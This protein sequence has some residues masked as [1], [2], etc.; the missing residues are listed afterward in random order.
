MKGGSGFSAMTAPEIGCGYDANAKVPGASVPAGQKDCDYL[1][2]NQTKACQDYCGPLT[3]NGCDCFGCC[4]DPH[5]PGNFI[6]AGSVNAAGTPTCKADA[7]TMAD[8]TL[9]KPCTP[10]LENSG[11]YKK[12]DHCELCFGKTT[13]PADCYMSVPDMA[14]STA[15]LA[16]QPPPPPPQT[17]LPGVQACGLVGQAPCPAGYYCITGCCAV[18]VL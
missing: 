18:V 16:G 5:R 17:C 8:P 6:Y 3:P 15:D 7:T 9:C 14:G 10:V 12:C 11:C 13:L 2:K 1:S 4:E